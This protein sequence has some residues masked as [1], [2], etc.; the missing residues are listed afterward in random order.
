MP[1]AFSEN[2]WKCSFE[3]KKVYVLHLKI[4]IT[5]EPF[6]YAA[7]KVDS[8]TALK[9]TTILLIICAVPKLD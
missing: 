2:Y 7:K 5:K 1:A 6:A 3:K 4:V 8:L 9:A